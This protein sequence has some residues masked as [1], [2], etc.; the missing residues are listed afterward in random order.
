MSKKHNL[1]ENVQRKIDLLVKVISIV[2]S[3]KRIGEKDDMK[4]SFSFLLAICLCSIQHQ[5]LTMMKTHS[6]LYDSALQQ[7]DSSTSS[8]FV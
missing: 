6:I 5:S 7:N 1:I 8:I 2:H 4:Q 3:L